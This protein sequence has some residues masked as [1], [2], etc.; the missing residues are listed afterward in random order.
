MVGFANH[1]GSLMLLLQES[2][3]GAD[4]IDTLGHMNVRF[5]LMRME[6]ANQTLLSQLG[7]R[8]NGSKH[9]PRRVDTYTRFRREQFEG[10]KLQT[11]GGVLG[12]GEGG[13][14]S[15]VEIRSAADND[16][17]ASFIVTTALF[18]RAS[19]Q[20]VALPKHLAIEH[21]EL[22]LE[23]P[24]YAKPRS[25]SLDTVNTSVT[26]EQLL[27][28]IPEVEGNGMMSG[29]RHTEIEPDDVDSSGWLRED[30]ELMFLPFSKMAR[31]NEGQHGPPVYLTDSGQRVGWAVMESRTL[32]LHLPRLGDVL[33]YFS[34]DLSVDDKS[35]LSRRWAFDRATGRLLGISDNVGVCIDLDARRAVS[36]PAELRANIERHQQP[37]LA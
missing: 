19:R 22:A 5:Y 16:V 12:L 34:A 25:L 28:C 4:E 24:R 13:M 30:V 10:A 18:Q 11:Y 17:A 2:I 8:S 32:N 36:W 26:H 37:Q 20:P 7:I 14:R 15:Y 3:V 23:L 6:Q 35:R 21:A 27:G 31:Q 9:F 29:K 1:L 33:D